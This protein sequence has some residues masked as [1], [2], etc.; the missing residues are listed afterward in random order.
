[1]TTLVAVRDT[2]TGNVVIGADSAVYRGTT[3]IGNTQK[4]LLHDGCALGLAGVNLTMSVLR[5]RAAEVLQGRPDPMVLRDRIG[6]VLKNGGIVPLADKE[7]AS[8]DNWQS[9]W[10]YVRPPEI[11]DLDGWLDPTPTHD[12]AS[13]GSGAGVALGAL[14]A[15]WRERKRSKDSDAWLRNVVLTA[16]GAACAYDAYSGGDLFV[17]TIPNE[18]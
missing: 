12:Y 4:W 6:A 14:Y 15:C 16:L 13:V 7:Q 2:G 17:T 5:P 3:W 1:M 11:W 18:G 10:L 9:E 8:A